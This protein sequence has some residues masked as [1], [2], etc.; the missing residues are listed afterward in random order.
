M[1]TPS[2]PSPGRG[3]QV[4]GLFIWCRRVMCRMHKVV[5]SPSSQAWVSGCRGE[6]LQ[7]VR[8]HFGSRQPEETG[9]SSFKVKNGTPRRRYIQNFA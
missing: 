8:E 1:S 7:V 9:L 5:R 3:N 2:S 6:I 4:Q